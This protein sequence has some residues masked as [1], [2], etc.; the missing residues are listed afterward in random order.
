MLM[1]DG[2]GR[3]WPLWVFWS[4]SVQ[5]LVLGFTPELPLGFIVTPPVQDKFSQEI[6]LNI[7]ENY[8]EE[9]GESGC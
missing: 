8:T 2:M 3:G 1:A 5:R 7:F 4:W 6:S 9:E